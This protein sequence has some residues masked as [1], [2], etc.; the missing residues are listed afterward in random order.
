MSRQAQCNGCGRMATVS[1]STF[2]QNIGAFFL[3][4]PSSISGDFCRSCTH[5]YFWEKSLIT[6]VVGWW[7]IISF[8]MTPVFLVMNIVAYIKAISDLNKAPQY[9]IKDAAHMPPPM[10]SRSIEEPTQK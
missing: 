9:G 4:F 8:F 10:P 1:T 3:R 5:K 7:G 6:L 2:R